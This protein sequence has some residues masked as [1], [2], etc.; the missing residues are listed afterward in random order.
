ML[1]QYLQILQYSCGANCGLGLGGL[2][3]LGG[4]LGGLGGGLGGLGGLGGGLGGLGGGLG[5]GF[6]GLGG[7]FGGLGGGL[8]G[9]GGLNPLFRSGRNISEL[10]RQGRE[11]SDSLNLNENL[12]ENKNI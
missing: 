8:G 5:L 10:Y 6:G 4:G 2:G 3:G 11:G 9:F 7:G 1:A 12:A